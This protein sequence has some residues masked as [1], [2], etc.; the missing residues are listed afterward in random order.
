M[1]AALRAYT[2][3]DVF[4]SIFWN[5]KIFFYMRFEEEFSLYDI[6]KHARTVQRLTVVQ[7][8]LYLF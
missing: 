4:V 1:H 6:S 5:S 8:N 2:E 7:I 3:G